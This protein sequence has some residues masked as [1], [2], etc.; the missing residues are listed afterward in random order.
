M[1]SVCRCGPIRLDPDTTQ[2]HLDINAGEDV[3]IQLDILDAGG[4]PVAVASVTG[5]IRSRA[6]AVLHEWSSANANVTTALGV[7]VLITT[8]AQTA[9]WWDAWGDAIWDLEVVDL[10]GER[11]RVAEGDV[12]VRQGRRRP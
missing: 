9:A 5:L 12:R 2:V 8:S 3:R 4:G 1:S 11:K 7:V 6:G 10:A